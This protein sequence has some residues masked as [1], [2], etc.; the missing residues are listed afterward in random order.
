MSRKAFKNK[1]HITNAIKINIRYKDGL[2]KKYLKDRTETN[3][4]AWKT[5][6]NKTK[7]AIKKSRITLL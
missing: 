1:P 7:A 3:E 5:F 2:Y 4:R 6:K